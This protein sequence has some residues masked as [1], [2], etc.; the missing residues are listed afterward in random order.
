MKAKFEKK[1]FMAAIDSYEDSDIVMFGVPYDGTTSF[2][3]GT[4]FAPNSIRLVSDGIESYSVYQDEDIEDIGFYDAGDLVIGSDVNSVI[5]QISTA[6]RELL[7]D[8]K[9][10]LVLGGEHLISFPIFSE[11]IKKYPDIVVLHFDAHTDLRED[12]LGDKLSHATVIRRIYE[13]FGNIGESIY[14]FG[15]RSGMKEEFDFAQ[16][17]T[18]IYKFNFDGVSAAVKKIGDRP[19]YIT[20]DLDVFDP[21]VLPGTGTPEPGG[22]FF[23]DFVKLIG[24]LKGIN[25]V[26]ADIVELS[27]D[28]DRS[29]VSSV[30]AA[31]VVREI[32]LLMKKQA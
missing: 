7:C 17:N 30:T 29:M 23:G 4:R 19:V 32:L 20:F 18:N 1:N 14:Q 26:C 28:Y 8:N 13:L 25:L 2:R 27:P 16:K 5:G 6:A 21:S 22:V 11:L 12:Y 10:M 3:P 15:I 31:K 9:K 24:D